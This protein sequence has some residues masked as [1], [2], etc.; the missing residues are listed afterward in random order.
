MNLT[1]TARIV[2]GAILTISLLIILVFNGLSGVSSINDGLTRVTEESTPMLQ[3]TSNVMT[4]LLKASVQVNN[5]TKRQ[6]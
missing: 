5:I 1:V 6:K 2:G 4:S 3:Q